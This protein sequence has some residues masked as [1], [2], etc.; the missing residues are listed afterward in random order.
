MELCLQRSDHLV[1]LRAAAP[2]FLVGVFRGLV[3]RFLC[4][5]L[6]LVILLLL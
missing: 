1:R 5:L 3:S 2:F 6:L 4:L